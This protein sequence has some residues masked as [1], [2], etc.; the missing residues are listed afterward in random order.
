MELSPE[1]VSA[2]NCCAP[3]VLLLLSVICSVAVS[4]PVCDGVKVTVI[5][6]LLLPVVNPRLD[7]QLLDSVKSPIFG[8]VIWKLPAPRVRFASPAFNSVTVA[9]LLLFPTLVFPNESDVGLRLTIGTG[10]TVC[11][12][13]DVVLPLWLLGE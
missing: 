5:V 13:P 12:S 1:P 9:G 7:G 10:V 2:T 6:H 4:T 3:A 11:V 8:P